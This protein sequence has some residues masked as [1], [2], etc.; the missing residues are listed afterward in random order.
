MR[1][2]LRAALVLVV[3]ATAGVAVLLTAAYRATQ[4]V[5]EFY[6][7]AL[8]KRPVEEKAAA[9][10]LER[11]VLELHN[12]A[13]KPGRWVARFS[14]EQINGWLAA[15][16]PVKFPGALPEGV[17]DPRVAIEPGRMRLAVRYDQ[18]DVSTVLSLAGDAYLTDKPN[19]VAVH[20]EHVRAGAF[21]VPL[22]QFL[23]Q[24][25]ERAGEAGLPIRWAE[26]E[27]DPVAL[28]V[29]PLDRKEFKG[30]KLQVE[31]L[32]IAAGEIVVSGRTEAPEGEAPEVEKSELAESIEAG[33]ETDAAETR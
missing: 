12:E 29:L 14:Q 3:L 6:Q 26:Q 10:Q 16:L 19:E 28:V 24:I 21:P 27:G 13:R 22:A 20:I 11:Q 17:S 5:P 15:D 18:G 33:A 7:A 1:N 8:A 23:D 30:K 9:D 4:H 32:E 31:Q 25:A 2:L